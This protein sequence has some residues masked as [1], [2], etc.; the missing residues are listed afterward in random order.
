[1]SV[2]AALGGAGLA[3]GLLLL[4]AGVRGTP[5][6]PPRSAR[7]LGRP[8]ER[9][10]LR[11]VLACSAGMA[12]ALLTRWPVGALLAAVLGWWL[13]S[14]FEAKAARQAMITRIEAIAAWTEMLRDT[15]AAAA[16]LEQAI[17]STA[18]LVPDPIREEVAG[19]AARLGRDS[20]EP[21]GVALRRFA[22]ALADPAAELVVG[23]LIL[24]AEQRAQQL[25]E[26]LGALA[27]STREEVAMRLRIETQ[28]A[29]TRTSARLVVVFTLA[30]AGALL[31]FN[32][33]YLAPFNSAVGQLVLVVVGLAFGSAFWWLQ[34]MARLAV[35]ERF[36]ATTSPTST[37]TAG[38]VKAGPR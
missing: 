16:G 1:V 36:L 8:V 34:R 13:P 27:T 9:L 10:Q 2:L 15:M 7:G 12:V 24:A 11:L 32:R 21:L 6:R 18:P 33:A 26:L 25:G 31:L 23:A 17:I 29:R 30:L 14:L 19:L 37:T 35:P 5:P 3:G 38:T 4:L 20:R 28:R 22:D